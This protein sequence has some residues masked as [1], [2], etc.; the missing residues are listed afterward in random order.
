MSN[1]REEEVLGFELISGKENIIG[2]VEEGVV[3]LIFESRNSVWN[4]GLSISFGCLDTKLDLHS[5]WL[6]RDIGVGEEF[7]IKVVKAD[8]SKVSIPIEKPRVADYPTDQ[9]LLSHY[10]ILKKELEDAGMI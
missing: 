7:G 4:S 10:N 2:G 5:N 9:Q 1:L 8:K 6:K 3:T